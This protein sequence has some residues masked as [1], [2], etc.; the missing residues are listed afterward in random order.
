MSHA[1]WWPVLSF[2]LLACACGS[3]GGSARS[4]ALTRLNGELPD[5]VIQNRKQ[6][7]T[8]RQFD[9]TQ[10]GDTEPA[11][12]N[13]YWDRHEPG[14]YVDVVSGE[15]LFSSK[16]KFDS[17]TG[18]PSFYAPLEAKNVVTRPEVSLPGR[19]EVRSR[20]ADSHLGHVFPDGPAPTGLRYC[21]NSAALRFIP[22]EHLAAD[23]Y[24]AYAER[25][26]DVKQL[27]EPDD[28]VLVERAAGGSATA[29]EL[30]SAAAQA[31]SANRAGVASDL[32]VAVLGGGC[33]WGMEE[34]LGQREGV[35]ATQ[36]GY[37]GGGA[38]T[39][40]YELASTGTTGHAETVRVVFNPKQVSY[41]ALI[42]W[43]FRIHDPTTPDQ[44]GHDVGSQYRSVIFFQSS[45]QQRV[46]NAIKA[47]LD[48]SRQLEA[49]VVT[50]IVPAVPFYPAEE[51]HQHYLQKHPGGYSCHYLRKIEL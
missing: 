38:E 19:I 49:P 28:G 27:D 2:A 45:E 3:D 29:G 22:A 42:K 34:M 31:A 11:F 12:D 30:S 14:L 41:E 36:V 24:G 5:E 23:G 50:D 1:R 21:I 48:Q 40:R 26:P 16:E 32:E 18:W 15:P 44:Q 37:A 4:A 13:A 51:H 47:R 9:V 43:F 7:L 17:G 39:A 35:L 46:A 20:R 33:F 6:Q 10:K 25:F 8:P